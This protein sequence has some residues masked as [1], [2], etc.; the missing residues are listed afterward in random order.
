M[1]ALI[2]RFLIPPKH[3]LYILHHVIYFACYLIN[4]VLLNYAANP[5]SQTKNRVDPAEVN[6]RNSPQSDESIGSS[7]VLIEL[8]TEEDSLDTR[9][10][11][12]KENGEKNCS[13][14]ILWNLKE[15]SSEDKDD[16][17]IEPSS[18]T[19]KIIDDNTFKTKVLKKLS[20]KCSNCFL[21]FD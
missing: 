7:A 1:V 21:T 12:G 11:K 19:R 13:I 8:R 5:I 20:S 17:C 9:S 15:D 16:S 6:K 10:G 4:F 14:D 3:F 2:R 18:K